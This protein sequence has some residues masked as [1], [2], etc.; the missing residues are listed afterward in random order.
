MVQY[1]EYAVLTIGEY[2]EIIFTK[3]VV[4]DIYLGC[5]VKNVRDIARKFVHRTL[6][7]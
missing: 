1:K 7:C 2:I 4:E 3:E 5:V 6:S